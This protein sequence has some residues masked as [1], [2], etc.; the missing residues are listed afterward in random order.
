ME[1]RGLKYVRQ[2]AIIAIIERVAY[3]EAQPA[4]LTPVLIITSF[5]S[6]DSHECARIDICQWRRCFPSA[7]KEEEKEEKQREIPL[8]NNTAKTGRRQGVRREERINL[9][10]IFGGWSRGR[11]LE[12]RGRGEGRGQRGAE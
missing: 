2:V 3:R 12:R 8:N 10:T 7:R 5:I 11:P 9:T 4:K 6:Y 1:F